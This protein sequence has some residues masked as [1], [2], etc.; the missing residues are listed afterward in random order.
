MESVHELA[1]PK[2][3]GPRQNLELVQESKEPL[4]TIRCPSC[5][6]LRSVAYRNRKT[7][8]LCTDCRKGK[9]VFRT[10][11]HRYWTERFTMDEIHDLAR[12]IWG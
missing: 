7:A 12:A 3:G 2:A 9:V 5:G 6:G 11:Y 1:T 4:E 8:A 10:K